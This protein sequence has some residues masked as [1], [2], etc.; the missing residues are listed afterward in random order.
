MQEDIPGNVDPVQDAANRADEDVRTP[1]NLS[2]FRGA[3][4]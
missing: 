4:L 1:K 2:I 3:K